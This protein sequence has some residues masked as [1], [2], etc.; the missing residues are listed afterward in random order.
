MSNFCLSPEI[1]N[2]VGLAFDIVGVIL[3][4]FYGLPEPI[5]KTGAGHLTWGENEEEATKWRLYKTRSCWGLALLI[6][7]FS[8]QLL[9]NWL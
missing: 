3:L 7:G 9:S 1:I 4:F 8:L 6:I 5:S 2:T